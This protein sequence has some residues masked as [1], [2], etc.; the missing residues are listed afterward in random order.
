[1]NQKALIATIALTLVGTVVSAGVTTEKDIGACTKRNP[2]GYCIESKSH[3]CFD[4]NPMTGQC[5]GWTIKNGDQFKDI[6]RQFN[7][8]NQDLVKGVKEQGTPAQRAKIEAERKAKIA[9]EL[10]KDTEAKN[11]AKAEAAKLQQ[12]LDL[13]TPTC[14][15]IRIK[16]NEYKNEY[17]IL[18]NSLDTKEQ[19]GLNVDRTQ[20]ELLN[21]K[22]SALY[23]L[24]DE[25]YFNTKVLDEGY[26]KPE[27]KYIEIRN[28]YKSKAISE[29]E[30]A[31]LIKDLKAKDNKMAIEYKKIIAYTKVPIYDNAK[32]NSA[33][34]S[35]L[36]DT[37]LD[38]ARKGVGTGV[39]ILNDTMNNVRSIQS[40][41]GI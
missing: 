15:A 5:R 8:Y 13:I 11:K 31:I 24:F 16:I 39:N 3:T 4:V 37:K 35:E 33:S 38:K 14:K 41:F 29:E 28:A 7:S 17:N 36:K 23:K 40:I 22:I 10:K 19:L 18:S 26:Y 2:K 1:M 34:N 21:Y 6:M 27:Q 25:T 30:Y 32:F 12:E 20:L 9:A